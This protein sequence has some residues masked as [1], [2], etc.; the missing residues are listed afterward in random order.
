[1]FDL[2]EK[3]SYDFQYRILCLKIKGSCRRTKS[4]PHY[5]TNSAWLLK[6]ISPY[7][8]RLKIIRALEWLIS[9]TR[10]LLP[11]SIFTLKKNNY[12]FLF[13][14]RR[15]TRAPFLTL[16]IKNFEFLIN[17]VFF[18]G[19]KRLHIHILC[20]NKRANFASLFHILYIT[21]IYIYI[22]LCFV[23][24]S[25][26]IS[27]FETFTD[28]LNYHKNYIFMLCFVLFLKQSK[29]SFKFCLIDNQKI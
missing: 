16:F 2:R 20:D 29:N 17:I 11:L 24:F 13:I 12:F 8:N 22:Y 3:H 15:R 18:F 9:R 1:M 14:R 5:N 27:L 10:I 21:Y 26:C 23:A 4:H 28:K 6:K 19:F 7:C 25:C